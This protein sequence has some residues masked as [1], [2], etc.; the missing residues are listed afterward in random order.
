MWLLLAWNKRD[1]TDEPLINSITNS[2]LENG[3]DIT[4]IDPAGIKGIYKI[5]LRLRI[6]TLR[7]HTKSRD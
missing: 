1:E 3:A 5:K 2:Y 4:G 6:V 7:S